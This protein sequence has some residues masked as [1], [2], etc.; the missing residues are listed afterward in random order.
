VARRVTDYRVL[1]LLVLVP[2][3]FRK[4]EPW[5][6]ALTHFVTDA[7][8]VN[9]EIFWI[10]NRQDGV[11]VGNANSQ[12]LMRICSR[13]FRSVLACSSDAIF[14]TASLNLPPALLFNRSLCLFYAEVPS[15]VQQIPLVVVEFKIISF[16]HHQ[17]IIH[18]KP[19]GLA[20]VL[21]EIKLTYYPRLRLS[22]DIVCHDVR[23]RRAQ[24]PVDSIRP[25]MSTPLLRALLAAGAHGAEDIPAGV[26]LGLL[27]V[28]VAQ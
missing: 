22:R 17:T 3:S 24:A 12:L 4:T 10:Q 13:C 26:A 1:K 15:N 7:V 8:I 9:C 6:I 25:L 19:L 18:A 2:K 21:V 5:R 11:A 28:L 14:S 16:V 27:A 20:L 23:F